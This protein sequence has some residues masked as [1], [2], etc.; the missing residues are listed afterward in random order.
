MHPLLAKQRTRTHRDRN[1]LRW[2]KNRL[3]HR[4]RMRLGCVASRML[5]PIAR[6]A[7]TMIGFTTNVV[8]LGIK[9]RSDLAFR[10]ELTVIYCKYMA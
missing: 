8:L 5:R 6:P 2:A 4:T 7:T 3:M 9:Q 1:L 10:A